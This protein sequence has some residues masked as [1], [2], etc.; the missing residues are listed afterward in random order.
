MPDGA[1]D[2]ARLEN[3][4]WASVLKSL[5]AY[6]MYRRTMQMR[7]RRVDALKFLLRNDSFPRAV[8]H[9]LLS[10]DEALARCPTA[11]TRG[12]R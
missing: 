1:A 4:Q 2:L 3:I 12:V 10:V 8:Y 7:V 11:T 6:Q 9:C 5:T